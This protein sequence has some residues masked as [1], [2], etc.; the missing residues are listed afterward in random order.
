M[1]MSSHSSRPATAG[2]AHIQ[3]FV[4]DTLRMGIPVDFVSTH[5]YPSDG[6]C[7]STKDPDCFAKKLLAARKIAQT[8][9]YPFLVTEYK[10]G[11]QG[12]SVTH[13]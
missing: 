10:D 3:D 4:D 11:L 12:G 8:A 13:R 2:I 9:G 1:L 7:S 6:Y 5:S